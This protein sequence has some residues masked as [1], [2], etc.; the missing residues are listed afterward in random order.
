M[1]VAEFDHAGSVDETMA[2]DVVRESGNAAAAAGA[3]IGVVAGSFMPVPIVGSIAGATIGFA[4]GMVVGR[5]FGKR[6]Q[7][8]QARHAD[9]AV[10]AQYFTVYDD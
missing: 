10:Q 3:S 7:N 8:A 5:A 1:P 2:F 6:E 9:A 4:I